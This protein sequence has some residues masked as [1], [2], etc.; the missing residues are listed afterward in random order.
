MK[1]KEEVVKE[2]GNLKKQWMDQNLKFVDKITKISVKNDFY[3][4]RNIRGDKRSPKMSGKLI[5]YDWCFSNCWYPGDYVGDKDKA[6]KRK[7]AVAEIKKM[8]KEWMAMNKKFID[9]IS[10]IAAAGNW[11]Y[12][13][14]LY[15]VTPKQVGAEIVYD[16][17]KYGH[18]YPRYLKEFHK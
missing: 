11:T 18:W 16:W 12:S 10:K 2:I 13:V 3:Y 17:C 4:G 9:K 6:D 14:G 8:K 1:T 7:K 15:K 5:V